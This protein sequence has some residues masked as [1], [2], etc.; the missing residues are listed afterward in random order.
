MEITRQTWK[1]VA[2]L[3]QKGVQVRKGE[4]SVVDEFKKVQYFNQCV[5]NQGE[6]TQNF[7]ADRLRMEERVLAMMV[8]KIIIP[9]GSNH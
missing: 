5:C 7:H 1:D 9:R 2:G 4:T 8:T 3:R 6:Q